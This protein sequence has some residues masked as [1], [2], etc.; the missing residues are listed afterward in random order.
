MA[1]GELTHV[2]VT[3]G[4]VRRLVERRGFVK[5]ADLQDLVKS[6]PELLAPLGEDLRF[7]PIGWE[8]PLGTGRLD[9]LFVDSE[10]V[11]TLVET[12]LK[13]NDESRREV[14]GQVLEYAMFASQWTLADLRATAT[15]F[16]QSDR[17]PEDVR[18]RS[19]E[20]AL[21]ASFRWTDEEEGEDEGPSR[22]DLFLA[23]I[24]A[25]LEK[26]HLRIV[27]GVDD[28]IENLEQ[29]V[30]YLSAHSDLQ[31]VLLQVTRFPVETD[32]SVL[33][34]TL[35]G[36]IKAAPG[37]RVTDS[38]V[39]TPSLTY[40]DLVDL[41]PEGPQRQAVVDLVETAR[42]AG[43]TLEYGPNGVSIRV[44]TA[45]QRPPVSIA[46]IFGPGRTGWMRTRD[47]SFGGGLF[48]AEWY[49]SLDPQ[50]VP[51]LQS[52]VDE[53]AA[54]GIGEEVRS[55]DA[56]ARALTAEQ[57]LPRLDELKTILVDIIRRL[58]AL[59]PASSGDAS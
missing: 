17:A 23:Q 18:G 24:E 54:R 38:R 16:F 37:R 48:N 52:Y 22:M 20:E 31:V 45:V 15:A 27:C 3:T 56:L 50:L 28:R 51:L 59:Q 9:L 14:I 30:V 47:L 36:D 39:R 13:A 11:L 5:E 19:L 8:V 21:A 32:S 58:A 57:A 26:G 4:G 35:H 2:V 49:S 41:F 44:R 1:G 40:G 10:G 55:K 25:N 7:A 42:S 46:W 6:S 33:I 53:L 12:K 29:L 34:P 43:A